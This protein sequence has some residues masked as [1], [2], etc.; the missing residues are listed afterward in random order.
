MPPGIA[1]GRPPG[2]HAGAPVAFW[3]WRGPR[4][5]WHLRTTTAGLFHEFRGRVAGLS[6]PLLAVH[7]TRVE[8]KD[9]IVMTPK[10]VWFRF[11]TKGHV[12]GFDFTVGGN[13]CV[14]FDLQ[15]DRGPHAER[16]FIGRNA[17]SPPSN[18]FVLCP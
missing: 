8:F 2:M 1:N 10:A 16:I 18:H 6:A 11:A 13:S 14:R 15:L 9:R 7:P 5:G 12:D 17:A 4:G 3:I